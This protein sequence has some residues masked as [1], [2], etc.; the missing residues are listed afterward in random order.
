MI[1]F[2]PV[3]AEKIRRTDLEVL[4]TKRTIQSETTIPGPD[5][6]LY[7]WLSFKFPLEEPNGDPL[8]GTVSINITERKKAEVE[9]REAKGVRGS[10][11]PRKERIPGQHESRDTHTP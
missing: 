8:V 5:G 11:Q 6:V 2:P 1:G 10:R 4:T 3:V 7:H 9:L